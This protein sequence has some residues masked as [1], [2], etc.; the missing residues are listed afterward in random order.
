MM[1]REPTEPEEKTRKHRARI[2]PVAG[3]RAEK[4]QKYERGPHRSV[5]HLRPVHIA[6][7]TAERVNASAE[8]RSS[9]RPLQ[10][11]AEHEHIDRRQK[12]NQYVIPVQDSLAQP[13][14]FQRRKKEQPV[15]WIRGARLALP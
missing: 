1:A 6:D 4:K 2:S 10:R 9:Q 15:Q 14:V 12:M 8:D 3:F 5:H 7:I 11:P 13:S